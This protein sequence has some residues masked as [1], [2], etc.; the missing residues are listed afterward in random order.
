[1]KHRGFPLLAAA[2]LVLAV[3]AG[4]ATRPH[5]GGTLHVCLRA[6][7]TSLDPNRA[8]SVASGNLFRLIF[9]TLVTLDDRGRPLPALAT[10][11]QA[12]S[13]SQRWQFSLRRGITFPD[14]TPLTPEVAVTSLRAANP[15]W[16]VFSTND[17]VVIERDSPEPDL[18]AELAL[19]RN[20]IVKR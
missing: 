5:Y 4:A 16:K 19:P 12:E 1:M 10:A 14:G 7:P 13:G 2:S 17:A 15:A 3:V 8:D 6:A 9:D 20:N 18:P 11:W